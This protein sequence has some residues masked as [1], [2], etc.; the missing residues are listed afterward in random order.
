MDGMTKSSLWNYWVKGE[1]NN[2]LMDD[3][4]SSDKE[5]EQAEKFEVIKYSLGPNE[6]Y[7]AINTCECNAWKR[8]EYSVSE[9]YMR[10]FFKKDKGW[11]DTYKEVKEL[12]EKSNLRFT[13]N[14]NAYGVTT[15]TLFVIH[16]IESVSRHQSGVSASTP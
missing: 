1:G 4:E 8:N 5:S 6:E 9:H 2:E 12:K 7:I 3:V 14:V 15:Q 11:T 13:V 16:F 10:F